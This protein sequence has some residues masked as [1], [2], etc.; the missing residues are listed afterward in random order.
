MR[1]VILDIETVPDMDCWYSAQTPKRGRKSTKEPFAPAYAHQVACIGVA[2]LTDNVCD[3]LFALSGAS[4]EQEKQLL[5]GF[6]AWMHGVNPDTLVTFNGRRFD[7]PVIELR[8]LRHGLA[9]PWYTAEQRRR[10]GEGAHVDLCEVLTSYGALG[11][12]DY[13]LDV[14]CRLIGLPGKGETDGSAVKEMFAAGEHQKIANYCKRDIAQTAHVYLRWLY[15][16][17]RLTREAYVAAA[18]SLHAKYDGTEGFEDFT[19]N[20]RLYEVG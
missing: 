14:F 6:A 2:T 8:S 7:L 5:A 9:Q 15:L 11:P 12:T 1:T 19:V 4:L 13:G 3:S 17:G 16:R 18:T 20:E 10:Y